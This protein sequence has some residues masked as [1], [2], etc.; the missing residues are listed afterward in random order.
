[1]VESSRELP[2]LTRIRETVLAGNLINRSLE[3]DSR[4]LPECAELW[5]SGAFTQLLL[6]SHRDAFALRSLEFLEDFPP[7]SSLQIML[8]Y[9][10]DPVP[11]VAQA[12]HLKFFLAND[13]INGIRDFGPFTRLAGLGQ[14]WHEGMGFPACMDRLERMAWTRFRPGSEGIGQLPEAPCLRRLDLLSTSIGSLKGVE[15]YAILSELGLDGATQLSDLSALRALESVSRLS[16]ENCRRIEGVADSI[17]HLPLEALRL[18]RCAAIPSLDFIE[19][20]RELQSLVFL[21]TDVL[22]GDMGCLLG[23]PAL[24]HVAFTKKKHFSHS[25]REVMK[26]LGTDA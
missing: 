16:L 25:E 17:R 22:D 5:A 18:I 20:L 24:A 21:D 26:A 11:L 3:I 19:A 7:V 9:P 4:H 15:R 23:H 14:P 10:V 6:S 12:A 8:R 1:M 13:G 2:G